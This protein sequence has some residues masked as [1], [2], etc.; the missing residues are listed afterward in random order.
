MDCMKTFAGI[1]VGVGVFVMVGVN[2]GVAV[3]A[4]GKRTP[5]PARSRI[6]TPVNALFIQGEGVG[7]IIVFILLSGRMV[8][9]FGLSGS[10]TALPHPKDK[11]GCSTPELTETPVGS[12]FLP[13]IAV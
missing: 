5:Q 8:F 1:G 6:K 10:T 4:G 3:A 12:G 9:S 7:L 11:E 13:G 2:E